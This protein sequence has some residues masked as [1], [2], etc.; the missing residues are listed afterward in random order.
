MGHCPGKKGH[1][2]LPAQCPFMEIT[3]SP[4]PTSPTEGYYC[5]KIHVT[6][7]P[8]GAVTLLI[9]IS[10]LFGNGAVLSLLGF[11][12]RSKPITV[13]I[14]HMAITDSAFFLIIIICTMLYLLKNE[15]CFPVTPM[16]YAVLLEQ[17]FLFFY[18]LGLYLLT[19]ISFNRCRSIFCPLRCHCQ[20]SQ[21]QSMVVSAMQGAISIAVIPTLTSLASLFLKA[22]CG[23]Q[24]QQQYKRLD[25]VIF[26][27]VLFALP[28]SF[29][30]LLYMHIDS[31]STGVYFLLACIHSTIKPFL[32]LSVGSCGRACSMGLPSHSP[33]QPTPLPS[34]PSIPAPC[35]KLH[36]LPIS[37]PP[38][39]AQ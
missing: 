3:V 8:M 17:L 39:S 32:Y 16:K 37:C 9:C 23:S 18:N 26:L 35:L 20:R 33:M 34:F 2:P 11:S 21:H 30:D 19:A 28:P 36:S 24:Q 7:V 14:F 5:C 1:I 22:K 6:D 15:S 27:M 4:S 38:H 29:C 10:G 25:I 31:I 12:N 13:Y